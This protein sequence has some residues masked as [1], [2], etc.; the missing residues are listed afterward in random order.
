MKPL[1]KEIACVH[2]Y[3]CSRTASCKPIE[4]RKMQANDNRILKSTEAFTLPALT[5]LFSIVQNVN[6]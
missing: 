3:E 1:L 6:K 5:A 2:F 4:T